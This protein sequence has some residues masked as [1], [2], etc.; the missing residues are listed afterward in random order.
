MP[1]N[2]NSILGFNGIQKMPRNYVVSLIKW[3]IRKQIKV[4]YMQSEA[5]PPPSLH[6]VQFISRIN[7]V[8]QSLHMVPINSEDGLDL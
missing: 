1:F 2:L 3:G 5:V 6:F 7:F 8:F 4:I